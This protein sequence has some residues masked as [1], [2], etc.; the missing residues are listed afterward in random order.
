[1]R[2]IA[3]VSL[4]TAFLAFAAQSA[5]SAEIT[6]KLGTLA[7]QGSPWHLLLKEAAQRWTE[8]S[9]GKVELK[10]FP[11]GTMGD[12]GDM[13]KKMRVGSLQA[14][15]LSTIGLHQIT[16]EPQALDLPLLVK[17]EDER[18]Y[19]IQKMA[20][21]LDAALEKKGFKVLTWSEIG[22]THFFSNKSRPTLDEMKTAKL[23]CWDGDPAS[24][25]AWKAGGFSPVVLSS[26]DIVPSMQ[27]GMVDTLVYTPTL[28]LALHV[29]DK[30]KYMMD[31]DWSTL[32]GATVVEK[33]TWDKIPADLQP[34]LIAVFTEL[35][36]KLT[37]QAQKMESDSLAKM[38]AQ[39]LTVVPVKDM[40]KWNAVLNDVNKT[41][42]GK[43]VPAE[44]FDKVYKLIKDYRAGK[45]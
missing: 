33:K 3:L 32:T 39:G 42:R 11:G 36:K 5:H 9:G 14:A 44:T 15:A 6:V 13:V 22:T 19:L 31:M 41:V 34:K 35:G 18:Q 23:F 28:V 45:R 16:P 7:P 30:A 40:D 29:N 27:T 25:D 8:V 4:C 24:A 2:K 37:G 26:T 10:I 21:E 17:N 20:P 43:V 1:M 38:K 12:E